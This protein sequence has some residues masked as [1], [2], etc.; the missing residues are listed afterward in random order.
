MRRTLLLCTLLLG[1]S[2]PLPAQDFGPRN[3]GA[4]G[5]MAPYVFPELRDTPPPSGYKPFYI[6]H[7][8]RHGSRYHIA[9]V[10][11]SNLP[12]EMER[13]REK[14]GL[15]EQGEKLLDEMLEVV[16]AHDGKD[17]DLSQLGAFQHRLL[18]ER[19]Y[20]R[21]PAVFRRGGRD[22][23]CRSSLLP[24]CIISM[25]SF[26]TSLQQQDKRLNISYSTGQ[27]DF[28]LL[29]HPYEDVKS[30]RRFLDSLDA[31]R[32]PCEFDTAPLVKRLF[33]PGYEPADPQAVAKSIYHLG[34]IEAGIGMKPVILD[35]FTPE[36]LRTQWR[37][38]NEWIFGDMGNSSELGARILPAENDLVDDFI[39][40]ADKAVSGEGHAADLRFGHDSGLLPLAGRMGL[41]GFCTPIPVAGAS[42]EWLSQER[43]PTAAN[44]QMVLY[45]KK[46]AP[47]LVK[48]LYNEIETSI[49]ALEP[50][51]G[52]YY[53]W[54]DVKQYWR[55]ND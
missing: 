33:K 16:R 54:E 5:V 10:L 27:K 19:M 12:A 35:A 36:E 18:A 48:F 47:V 7:Y 41:E 45:R 21:Y 2:C 3:E 22:V 38:Y 17:G 23:S 39:L 49:P 13:A 46:G 15:T 28:H 25:S 44:L 30:N 24:R 26:G 9:S 14:G 55:S 37:L 51:K 20:K 11:K 52:P 4:A 40:L 29:C 34:S 50:V 1:L 32:R 31:A 8:G 43:I 53:R 6:S 42:A